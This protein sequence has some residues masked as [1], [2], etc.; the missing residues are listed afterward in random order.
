MDHH[1][2]VWGIEYACGG[3][4][5]ETASCHEEW[6]DFTC[7]EWHVECGAPPCEPDCLAAVAKS[8][9]SAFV[10]QVLHELVI[11]GEGRLAYNDQR[12]SLQLL[13]C[14]GRPIADVPV[15][16]FAATVLESIGS[17]SPRHLFESF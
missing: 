8:D 13:N 1:F 3:D 7:G 16:A 10:A 14:D 17:P 6:V 12:Q 15:S 9:G 4:D 5:D 2:G 11:S